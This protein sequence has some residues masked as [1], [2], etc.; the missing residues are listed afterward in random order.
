[1]RSSRYDGR[2]VCVREWGGGGVG[3]WFLFAWCLVGW[4][5]VPAAMRASPDPFPLPLLSSHP[6]RSQTT[7]L[8][9]HF[10]GVLDS[11]VAV[12]R[13]TGLFN[14]V[15]A[16]TMQKVAVLARPVKYNRGDLIQRQGA[17][18]DCFYVLCKGVCKVRA[19]GTYCVC[20]GG[21]RGAR[22]RVAIDHSWHPKG[23]WL[24]VLVFFA[25]N[26]QFRQRGYGLCL[27]F[28][29]PAPFIVHMPHKGHRILQ[30]V[31]AG[32]VSW[33]CPYRC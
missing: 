24:G 28:C 26:H 32:W 23:G 19:G 5:I 4:A 1:M 25:P 9:D 29:A 33:A 11:R 3:W 7:G 15:D 22:P 27:L 10:R 31:C 6:P 13:R 2:G 8:F 21:E 12:L 30:S 16:D 20:G 18:A 17:P 14:H